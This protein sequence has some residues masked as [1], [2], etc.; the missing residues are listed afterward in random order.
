MEKDYPVSYLLVKSTVDGEPYPLG[1]AMN[2]MA[3]VG[4]VMLKKW[5]LAT[6]Q[7]CYPDEIMQEW[8]NNYYRTITCKVTEEEFEDFKHFNDWVTVIELSVNNAEVVLCF[9][10]RY[11]YHKSFKYLKLFK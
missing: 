11:E 1:K 3:H 10:P 6:S 9:K 2:S 7:F 8:I 4:I 5:P